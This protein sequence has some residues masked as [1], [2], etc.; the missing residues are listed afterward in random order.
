MFLP[1]G[2]ILGLSTGTVCLAY[3]GPVL[4][5]Y[6]LGEGQTV[7]N[8]F[9]SVS[10][11]LAGRLCAYLI[12]GLITGWVGELLQPSSGNI[13]F[14]GSVYIALAALM[15]AYGFYRFR[16]ICLG[17]THARISGGMARKW[18]GLL[19][20]SGGF[21]TGMNLCPPF[22]LAVAGSLAGQ[23]IRSAVL[24]FLLFFAGTAVYFLPLPLLG[25]FRRKQ[26]L[27][28]IGKF[29]AIIAG[30]FYLYK[31]SLMLVAGLGHPLNNRIL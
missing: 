22:L 27:Q 2:F 25:F 23:S 13:I 20:F 15:I 11:F 3:C 29:A 14:F 30:L 18:P 19:P 1:E 28:A 31:G 9:I 12:T 8:N 21:V 17:H 24:F 6:L 4:M 7:A 10:V 26:V 5:P 16:E